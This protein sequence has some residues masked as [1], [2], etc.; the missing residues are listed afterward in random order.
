VA[1][2]GGT[3]TNVFVPDVSNMPLQGSPFGILEFSSRDYDWSD[4]SSQIYWAILR[5]W[6]SRL[7]Q[8]TAE[9]E[10]WAHENRDWMLAHE[11]KIQFVIQRNGDVTDIVLEMPAGCPPLDRSALDALSEVILPPLPADFPRDREL[12]RATFI[13]RG[14]IYNMR[15]VFE[16]YRRIGYF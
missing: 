4:Y 3:N 8:T 15:Q 2:G 11:S 7:Y 12:V 1:P 10:K 5:A 6:Y 9:F 16:Y 14:E 13:A